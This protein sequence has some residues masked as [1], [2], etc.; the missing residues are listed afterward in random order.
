MMAWCSHSCSFWVMVVVC[1]DSNEVSV[2]GGKF[3]RGEWLRGQRLYS[4]IGYIHIKAY[5]GLQE[6]GMDTEA[7]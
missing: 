4:A 1:H 5:S 6:R 2:G 7:G 3:G